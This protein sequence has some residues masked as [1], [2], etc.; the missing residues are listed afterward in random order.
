ATRQA[1][2][3]SVRTWSKPQGRIRRHHG[4]A[5]AETGFR[6]ASIALRGPGVRW[7]ISLDNR[8]TTVQP[9]NSPYA[10]HT[11]R[12]CRTRLAARPKAAVSQVAGCW[13]WPEQRCVLAA[14]VKPMP[15]VVSLAVAAA[16][17]VP[18]TRSST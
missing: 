18:P 9:T 14:A 7:D 2:W 11:R 4:I 16:T 1:L 12:P 15:L 3:W 5:V 17:P 10:A 6:R 8:G 13:A